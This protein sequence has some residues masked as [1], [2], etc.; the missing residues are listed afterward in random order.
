MV[1]YF[2]FYIKYNFYIYIFNSNNKRKNI[3]QIC[4]WVTKSQLLERSD[5]IPKGTERLRNN[6][7]KF[8]LKTDGYFIKNNKLHNLKELL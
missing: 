5:F 8:L 3:L 7:T 1:P 6:R 4:W 2:F